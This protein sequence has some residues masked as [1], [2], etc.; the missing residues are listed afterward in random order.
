MYYKESIETMDR[1]KLEALQS[2]RLV[3]LVKRVYE[4]STFYKSALDSK[5]VRPQDIKG[6]EDI[7]KLPFTNKS[8]LRDN[9]PFGMFSCPMSQI[10]RIHA[11]SGTTGKPTVVGYTQNDINIVGRMHRAQPRVRRRRPSQHRAGRIRIRAVHRRAG[12]ALRR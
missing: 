4:N 8:D 7:G 12:A 1:A 9:Y 10:I 2:E 5:G 6:I 3:A 11:S